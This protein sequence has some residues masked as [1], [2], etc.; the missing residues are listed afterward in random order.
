M[1][2]VYTMYTPGLGPI[3]GSRSA[4]HASSH[5][6]PSRATRSGGH[7]KARQPVISGPSSPPCATSFGR[8]NKK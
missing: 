3:R 6:C 5:R 7:I 2:L 1:S 4:H 8:A